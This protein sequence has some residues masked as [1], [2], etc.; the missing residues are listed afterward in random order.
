MEQQ[1]AFEIPLDQLIRIGIE[2]RLQQIE[3]EIVGKVG[4]VV[5]DGPFE[6]LVLAPAPHAIPKILGTY[7]QELWP[8]I[9]KAIERAPQTVFNIGCGEGYYAV[10]LSRRLPD[11]FTICFDI[12]KA[13]QE[14]CLQTSA[15]NDAPVMFPGLPAFGGESPEITWG[16]GISNWHGIPDGKYGSRWLAIIDCEGAEL[17]YLSEKNCK[18]LGGT[19]LIIECHDF[20]GQPVMKILFER[21]GRTHDIEI[22]REAGRD[23]AAIP[24]LANLGSYDRS[25]A[26]CEFRPLPMAW[27]VAWARR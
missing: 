23:T 20:I 24:L 7:E 12:G 27:L 17:D 25:L 3:A 14:Q 18:N 11:V 10:G 15:L 19:D 9:A 21:L 4:R 22:I 13:Q 1:Q 26:V 2:A 5:Q 6:G 16:R 8:A